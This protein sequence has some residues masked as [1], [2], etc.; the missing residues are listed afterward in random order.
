MGHFFAPSPTLGGG[1]GAGGGSKKFSNGPQI[2]EYVWVVCRNIKATCLKLVSKKPT[3]RFFTD[4]QLFQHPDKLAKF[5]SNLGQFWPKRAIFEFS[6]KMRIHHFF[7][8][9]KTRLST[10]NLQILMNR[11]RKKAKNLHFWEFWPKM[12]NFGQFLAKMGKTGFFSKK[13]LEQFCHAYKP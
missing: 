11:L 13:R 5:R 1:G 6:H 7:S 3:F 9:T 8:I 4:F 10:T 12:V 2:S